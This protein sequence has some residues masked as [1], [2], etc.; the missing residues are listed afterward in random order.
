MQII[1]KPAVGD[2]AFE[3]DLKNLKILIDS[4]KII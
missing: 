1:Q 2:T 4:E 3:G